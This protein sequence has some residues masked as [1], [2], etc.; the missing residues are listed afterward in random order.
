MIKHEVA[1]KAQNGA[2]NYEANC[3]VEEYTRGS[4]S[5]SDANSRDRRPSYELA[6]KFTDSGKVVSTHAIEGPIV[7]IFFRTRLPVHPGL[8]SRSRS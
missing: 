6:R 8:D 7:V 3:C 4:L 5:Q 2:H 1:H